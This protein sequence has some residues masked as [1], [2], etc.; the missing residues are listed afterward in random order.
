MS[1]EM[2][3]KRQEPLLTAPITKKSPQNVFPNLEKWER[4]FMAWNKFKKMDEM[5]K[6]YQ[7]NAS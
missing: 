1:A 3:Y 5:V 6:L 4:K 2:V 7:I